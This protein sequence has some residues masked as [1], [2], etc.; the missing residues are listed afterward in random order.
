MGRG[1]TAL[2]LF[3]TRIKKGEFVPRRRGQPM[4]APEVRA[5][6]RIPAL[7][8]DPGGY[9]STTRRAIAGAAAITGADDAT[10]MRVGRQL[11]RAASPHDIAAARHRAAIGAP[12]AS[13]RTA[14]SAPPCSASRIPARQRRAP[15]RRQPE[16]RL[17][18]QQQARPVHQRA[19]Q[20][21]HLLLAARQQPGPRLAA[22]RRA[23]GRA[24]ASPRRA[25]GAAAAGSD[26]DASR[27]S[28]TVRPA[29]TRRPSGT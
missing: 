1:S 26:D 23:W 5:P 8:S 18:E 27:F 2:A 29:K 28:R 10:A 12:S 11:A 13:W 7:A 14:R 15:Q 4:G 20:C 17:V 25:G 16:R 21:Q 22:A 24:P 19:R 3:D 6:T 9:E